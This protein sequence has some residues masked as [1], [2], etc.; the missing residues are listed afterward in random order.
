MT[1][2]EL[3]RRVTIENVTVSR[4]SYGGIKRAY[5]SF[6]TVWAET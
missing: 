6:R 3:D 2:G 1:I 5:E 4:N